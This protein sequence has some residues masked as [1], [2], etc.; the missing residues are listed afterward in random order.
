MK[1]EAYGFTINTDIRNDIIK[2]LQ[3]QWYMSDSDA[4]QFPETET[5]R[6][7][8]QGEGYKQPN[9]SA[10]PTSVVRKLQ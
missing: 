8:W 3:E 4:R 10:L 9:K 6:H 7:A 2:L 5:K 1:K